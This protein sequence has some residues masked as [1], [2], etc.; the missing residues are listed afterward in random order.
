VAL[1]TIFI[2]SAVIE[3]PRVS[4]GGLWLRI[5]H[6]V[7]RNTSPSSC[8]RLPASLWTLCQSVSLL[9]CRHRWLPG[10]SA[11]SERCSQ[12]WVKRRRRVVH[13]CVMCLCCGRVRTFPKRTGASTRSG[14]QFGMFAG[15]V[16]AQVLSWVF[17]VAEKLLLGMSDEGMMFGVRVRWR[18]LFA[19]CVSMH[20]RPFEA[21]SHALTRT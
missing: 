17:G 5:R 13:A 14:A 1:A 6:P 18:V 2:R 7:F 10:Q 21:L 20:S 9:L 8:L 3:I 4:P 15:C 12:W 16:C 11:G 19:N